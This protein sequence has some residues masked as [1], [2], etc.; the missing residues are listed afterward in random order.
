V[1]GDGVRDDDEPI[2]IELS[3]ESSTV[4]GANV[5]ESTVAAPDK[6]DRGA[7]ELAVITVVAEA[8]IG[9]DVEEICRADD[10][11]I[12]LVPR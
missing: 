8:D 10:V 11:D 1:V 3:E 12:V 2:G 9:P 6:D 7:E 5:E 4:D